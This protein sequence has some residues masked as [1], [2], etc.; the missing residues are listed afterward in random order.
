MG[1]FI[2]LTGQR[3]GRLTV[4]EQAA[5]YTSPSG[6]HRTQWLCMCD[7]GNSVIVHSGN[8][9]KENGTKSCGCLQKEIASYTHKGKVGSR[10]IDLSGQKFGRLTVIDRAREFVDTSGKHRFMYRCLC[11]CGEY[12]YVRPFSLK[13]GKIQSCGCLHKEVAASRGKENTR[14]GGSRRNVPYEE[15][16]LYSIWHGMKQRCEN[17]RCS[18]YK[19]WG[20]RGIRVCDEWHDFAYFQQWA[21]SN[22]YDKSL[23]IDRIDV[24]GNYEPSNCRWCTK[25][26][27][28]NNQR[29]NR[30]VEVNGEKHTIAEWSRITGIKCGT[31]AGR[32]DRGWEPAAAIYT[33]VRGQHKS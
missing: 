17:Q 2:D 12:T 19:D 31:I 14:H 32:L 24:N 5:G 1:K 18:S 10:F 27:Q 21:L 13:S 23:S 8:L 9:R 29:S 30:F 25:I 33:E 7:C 6:K 26:E 3:F 15:R 28:M 22:G 16:R 11:D 20:G 4:I